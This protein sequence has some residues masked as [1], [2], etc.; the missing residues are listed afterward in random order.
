M[1]YNRTDNM[2]MVKRDVNS[3]SLCFSNQTDAENVAIQYNQDLADIFG[4]DYQKEFYVQEIILFGSDDASKI[5][6]SKDDRKYFLNSKN[7]DSYFVETHPKYKG[8]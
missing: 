8:D 3:F 6:A 4:D 2:F 1:N 5:I 7:R